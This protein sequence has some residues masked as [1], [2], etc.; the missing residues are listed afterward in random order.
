MHSDSLISRT[1][2]TRLD[3]PTTVAELAIVHD[4]LPIANIIMLI[5]TI[6]MGKRKSRRYLLSSNVSRMRMTFLC[7]LEL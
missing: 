6:T 3:P 1:A 7:W 2:P 4:S 5:T